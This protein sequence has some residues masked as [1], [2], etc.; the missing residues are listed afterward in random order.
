MVTN[1]QSLVI[2]ARQS[3]TEDPFAEEE[4]ASQ[5]DDNF[6]SKGFRPEQRAK[7]FK[8]LKKTVPVLP[9]PE[10]EHPRLED[11]DLPNTEGTQ[12]EPE[13]KNVSTRMRR[14]TNA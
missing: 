12:L 1:L 5:L 2:S 4:T 14:R 6:C 8:G 13:K 3:K 11:I 9:E 10:I 7:C